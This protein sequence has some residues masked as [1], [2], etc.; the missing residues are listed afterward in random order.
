[1]IPSASVNPAPLPLIG[2]FKEVGSA[3][4]PVSVEV[5]IDYQCVHCESFVR[6]VTPLLVEQYVGT[7]KVRLLYRDF[8]LPTHRYAK[9]AAYYADA[10]G[11]LGYYDTAMKQLFATRQAWSVSGDIDTQ[12]AQVLPVGIME[13]LRD[14][15]KNDADPDAALAADLAAGQEDR[16]DRVPF[17]VIVSGGKRQAI[18]ETPLSFDVLKE[19]SGSISAVQ[20]RRS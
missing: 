5:Y 17:V 8:P 10:A 15:M 9:L 13:K 14:R 12:I 20:Q 16:L 4:A 1:M 11:E 7:G 3:S 2:N 19:Q 18:T 6:D